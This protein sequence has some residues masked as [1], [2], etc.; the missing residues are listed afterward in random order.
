MLNQSKK[1][2]NARVQTKTTTKRKNREGGYTTVAIT[3][4]LKPDN[5]AGS[6]VFSREKA[7]ARL[8]YTSGLPHEDRRY[9]K[10][11]SSVTLPQRQR[12]HEDCFELAEHH[13][14]PS[15]AANSYATRT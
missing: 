11:K 8:L 12:K 13:T 10:A 14:P 4:N 1:Q 15:S 9:N 6:C 5:R 2:K 7:Q 3:T